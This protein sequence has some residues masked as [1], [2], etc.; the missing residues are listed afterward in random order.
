MGLLTDPCWSRPL[1]L[2]AIVTVTLQ[3]KQPGWK[4]SRLWSGI[5]VDG[6]F[7]VTQ[8]YCWNSVN[9][10]VTLGF[11]FS[12]HLHQVGTFHFLDLVRLISEEEDD[13]LHLINIQS[14]KSW[15]QVG[16]L[17]HY[18][19]CYDVWCLLMASV[20]QNLPDVTKRAAILYHCF[21]STCYC[22]TLSINNVLWG[23]S[24]K[25]LSQNLL[26]QTSWYWFGS[27]QPQPQ[28]PSPVSAPAQNV[29]TNCCPTNQTVCQPCSIPIGTQLS[30]LLY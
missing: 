12:D 9:W 19:Q 17:R 18:R 6:L 3:L 29:R 7:A 1:S 28:L 8:F 14:L 4:A 24:F 2:V 22:Q 5:K 15:T 10:N 26:P 27:K 11:P 13:V 25:S 20:A 30:W 23:F 16:I 21:L